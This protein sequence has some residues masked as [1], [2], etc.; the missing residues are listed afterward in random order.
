MPW[1]TST[2]LA[3]ATLTSSRSLHSGSRSYRGEAKRKRQRIVL[4]PLD[5]DYRGR[6]IIRETGH[7]LP[8]E[9]VLARLDPRQPHGMPVGRVGVGLL[10]RPGPLYLLEDQDIALLQPELAGR[11][12]GDGL[13]LV[14]FGLVAPLLVGWVSLRLLRS[15][16]LGLRDP[17][18]PQGGRRCPT[19]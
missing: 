11:L 3:R 5:L 9:W 6:K 19:R 10:A 2:T 17:E 7:P 13:L 12:V 16:R 18:V 14:G 4:L 1:S 8:V 15:P